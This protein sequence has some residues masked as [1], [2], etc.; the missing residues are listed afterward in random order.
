MRRWIWIAA[1]LILAACGSQDATQEANQGSELLSV[2]FDGPDDWETG[3]YP[4]DNPTSTLSINQGRY[5]IDHQSSNRASFAWGIGGQPAEDVIIDIDTEQLSS[6]KDNLYGVGCRMTVDEDGK[7]TGYVL[8]IS[9]DGH[10]GIARM[11]NNSL[12]F[13][14][15]WHQSEQIKQGRA[16]NSLRA[17]CVENYFALYVNGEFMGEI[18][19]NRY[20]RA[21]QMGLIAGVNKDGDVSIIFDNLKVYEGTLK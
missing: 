5:Q 18:T 4:A 11:S 10:Y 6:E 7:G 20:R 21:G 19:D 17:V 12:I 2:T 13:L 3:A 16:K 14:L 9:G 1:A 8:L 15:N